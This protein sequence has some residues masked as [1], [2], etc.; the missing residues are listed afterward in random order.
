MPEETPGGEASAPADGSAKPA[1]VLPGEDTAGAAANPA[2]DAG[3]EAAPSGAQ[4]QPKPKEDL[5]K[6]F[7]DLINAGKAAVTDTLKTGAKAL[8][9]NGRETIGVLLKT[10]ALTEEDKKLVAITYKSAENHAVAGRQ[11][12]A[13]QM[14]KR[15][16]NF[17]RSD[18]LVVKAQRI[19]ATENYLTTVLGLLS[20]IGEGFL[21]KFGAPLADKATDLAG[22]ALDDILG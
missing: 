20:G 5:S 11:K 4:P 12:Q 14:V 19:E 2:T 9:K 15:A 21:K 18:A 17:V 16:T 8:L 13:E 6:K 3:N 7:D 22:E 10:S 1:T